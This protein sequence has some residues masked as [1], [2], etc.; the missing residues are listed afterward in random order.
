MRIPIVFETEKHYENRQLKNE[1]DCKR[2]KDKKDEQLS[3]SEILK[4]TQQNTYL[5][6]NQ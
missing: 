2:K 4:R 5:K 3:F 1:Y 6:S